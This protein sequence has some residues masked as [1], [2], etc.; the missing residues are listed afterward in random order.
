MAPKVL[1]STSSDRRHA[2]VMTFDPSSVSPPG[3]KIPVDFFILAFRRLVQSVS[4]LLTTAGKYLSAWKRN[5]AY[6][7]DDYVLIPRSLEVP[8][9][10]PSGICNL[11]K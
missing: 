3:A 9:K 7:N 4:N 8:L 11:Y 2:Y 10:N 5:H 1:G 6:V